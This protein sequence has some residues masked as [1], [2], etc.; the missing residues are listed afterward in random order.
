MENYY[1]VTFKAQLLQFTLAFKAECTVDLF[2]KKGKAWVKVGE[3]IAQ[4]KQVPFTNMVGKFNQELSI[5]SNMVF[6][7]QNKTFLEKIVQLEPLRPSSR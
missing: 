3:K 2:W 1:R 4:S 5:N 7:V 6:D